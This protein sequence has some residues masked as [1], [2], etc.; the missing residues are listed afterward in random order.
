MTLLN[1]CTLLLCFLTVYLHPSLLPL[2]FFKILQWSGTTC[3]QWLEICIGKP[4]S[5]TYS[6]TCT[7]LMSWRLS[8]DKLC[9]HRNTKICIAIH[10]PNSA[11]IIHVFAFSKISYEWC[12]FAFL[13]A[14]LIKMC[15]CFKIICLWLLRWQNSFCC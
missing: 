6:Y 14:F 13:L 7:I 9:H 3:S 1:M 2:W 10:G 8:F 5:N 15:S 11:I 4:S 12:S